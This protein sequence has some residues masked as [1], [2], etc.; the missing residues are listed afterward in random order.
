MALGFGGAA[1][2]GAPLALETTAR[3]AELRR[4]SRTTVHIFRRARAGKKRKTEPLALAMAWDVRTCVSPLRAQAS[5]A[6][7]ASKTS[8]P[9]PARSSVRD[10][11]QQRS[12]TAA[13]SLG[14][15][16]GTFT[17]PSLMDATALTGSAS[18]ASR[19]VVR[20]TRLSRSRVARPVHEPSS[21]S[22][23]PSGQNSGVRRRSAAQALRS[24]TMRWKPACPSRSRRAP[25]STR[26]GAPLDA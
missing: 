4:P 16:A 2:A 10:D 8:N 1:G 13:A 24:T 9:P 26:R 6:I 12:R 23:S 15:L 14:K 19:R 3:G 21:S 17:A 20:S 18:V 25:S 7:A 22:W 5:G 11:A